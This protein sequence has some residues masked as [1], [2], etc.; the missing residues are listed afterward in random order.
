VTEGGDL[1]EKSGSVTELF[2]YDNG[3]TQNGAV[4]RF[5]RISQFR[6]K[7]P[8]FHNFGH[9]TEGRH[10][11]ALYLVRQR[12]LPET[13][14]VGHHRDRDP[15]RENP[16]KPASAIP[17]RHTALSLTLPGRFHAAWNDARRWL[18]PSVFF[19]PA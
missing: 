7:P 17:I 8:S 19:S 6:M 2:A 18:N 5:C 14:L 13:P 10:C 12:H 3:Q 1:G 16:A 15:P 4:S 11:S 9:V